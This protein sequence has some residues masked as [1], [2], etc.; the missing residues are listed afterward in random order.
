[1]IGLQTCR[2]ESTCDWQVCDAARDQSLQLCHFEGCGA[3]EVQEEGAFLF[4]QEGG[5]HHVVNARRDLFAI[6]VA[7]AASMM[8][9]TTCTRVKMASDGTLRRRTT[10]INVFVV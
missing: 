6:H 9:P 3:G 2:V 7:E 8:T 1:M 4:G 10:T 5:G